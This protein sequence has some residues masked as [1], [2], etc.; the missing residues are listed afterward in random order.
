MSRWI[1]QEYQD[2]VLNKFAEC[3]QQ[4]I[5]SIQPATYFEAVRPPLW[6]SNTAVSIGDI[7]HAPTPDGKV[8]E[9]LVGGTTGSSEPGWG[10]SQNQEF[11]DNDVT[12]KTHN[13]YAL[14]TRDTVPGDFSITDDVETDGRRLTISEKIG[15]IVHTSGVVSH[16]SLICSTDKTLRY[17]STSQTTLGTN[18][19]ES[20]RTTIFKSFSI[21]FADPTEV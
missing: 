17:V 2:Y 6:V 10:T 7:V 11:S 15:I 1:L 3:D 14:A 8:F 21:I 5:C 13:N 20:G 4:S 16:T 19:V 9:C 18:D 12:W